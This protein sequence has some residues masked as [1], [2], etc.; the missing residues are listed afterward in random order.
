MASGSVQPVSWPALHLVEQENADLL[1]IH[2]VQLLVERRGV[3]GDLHALFIGFFHNV[4]QQ[5]HFILQ[6]QDVS[7]FKPAQHIVHEVLGEHLVGAAVQQDAVLGV[8]VHLDDGMAG[9]ALHLADKLRMDA[10]LPAGIQE[11]LAVLADQAAVVYLGAG[12][13]QGPWTG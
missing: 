1:Q 2:L 13:G 3:Q 9:L 8:P 7:P 5:V 6:Q 10:I 12:L 11:R 4:R